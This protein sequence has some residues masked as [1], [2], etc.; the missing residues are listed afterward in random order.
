MLRQSRSMRPPPAD[1]SLRVQLPSDFA[2][3][4]TVT[5]R[6]I[7]TPA[8][9][10]LHAAGSAGELQVPHEAALHLAV[11]A[12]ALHHALRGLVVLQQLADF[13]AGVAR[14]AR[15]AG[16]AWRLEQAGVLAL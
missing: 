3:W 11:G 13:V 6:R 5:K 14:A 16:D 8:W 10:A 4:L 12:E 1:K 15:D 9:R 2:V 7:F